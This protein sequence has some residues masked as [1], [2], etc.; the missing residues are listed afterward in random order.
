MLLS[1]FHLSL[2]PV[3]GRML[4][5]LLHLAPTNTR[6]YPPGSLHLS[7]QRWE[8]GTLAGKLWEGI[9]G[10]DTSNSWFLHSTSPAGMSLMSER[11][12]ARQWH[13][14]KIHSNFITYDNHI[15]SAQSQF[16]TEDVNT[17]HFSNNSLLLQTQLFH[18]IYLRLLSTLAPF[19]TL[20]QITGNFSFSWCFLVYK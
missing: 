17:L 8:K 14:P 7:F 16:S 5:V 15:C 6:G 18:R 9:S 11:M 1:I 3:K 12:L 10:L 13:L 19:H 20:L 4:C 2:Q